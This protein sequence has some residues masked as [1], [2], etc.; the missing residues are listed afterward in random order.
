MK[1]YFKSPPFFIT[2]GILVLVSVIVYFSKDK[3]YVEY[4]DASQIKIV[5]KWELPRILEEVSGISYLDNERIACVQDEV[6][7]VFIFNLV[8]KTI[9]KKINFSKNDDFEGLAT[10]ENKAY[11]LRSDGEIF[12]I[13]D[14]TVENPKIEKLNSSLSY[15]YNF[16]GLC[17]DK[18][19]NRLLLAAKESGPDKDKNFKPVFE[20]SLT[21]NKLNK[22]PVFKL[23]YDNPIFEGL[24]SAGSARVFRTSEIKIH[25]TTG[26]IYMLD[27]VIGKLLILNSNWEAKDLYV[28]N[29]SDF[30]QPEGITFSPKG[31]MF[32]SNE[33]EWN[34][35]NILEVE[36]QGPP[37]DKSKIEEDSINKL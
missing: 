16:E 10:V 24:E 4:T 17:Y 35:A 37:K 30:P 15:E 29:P 28:F 11:L 27:G 21:T 25:P 26:D 1:D 31:K 32:I 7:D 5:N 20:F 14:I 22:T 18:K 12:K 9:E 6:G 13:D 19:H 34:P 23:N 2:I 8:S 33:G 3:Y 36:L